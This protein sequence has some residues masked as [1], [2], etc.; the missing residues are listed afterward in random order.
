MKNNIYV[1][2]ALSFILTAC[3]TVN[4]IQSQDEKEYQEFASE[5]RKRTGL[6]D[7]EAWKRI[8]KE[9]GLQEFIYAQ[10]DY[11]SNQRKLTD[12]DA[13]Y[14]SVILTKYSGSEYQERLSVKFIAYVIS[15]Y[16]LTQMK[17]A[18]STAYLVKYTREL[19]QNS[20]ALD[21]NLSYKCLSSVRGLVDK[22]EYNAMVKKAKFQ[23]RFFIEL[24]EKS[25]AEGKEKVPQEVIEGFKLQTEEYKGHLA[26][27]EALVIK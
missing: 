8:Y 6:P 10:G 23:V 2:L 21:L 4:E 20:G 15:A 26:K 17:D 19:S 14:N 16:D 11:A 7:P 22:N 1:G 25:L 24:F 18:E 27:F 5:L 12:L 9:S 3:S 13:F